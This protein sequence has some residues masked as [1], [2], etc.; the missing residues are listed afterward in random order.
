MKRPF[1]DQL[2]T[3]LFKLETNR[4][5]DSSEVDDKGRL[6]EPMEW[7]EQDSLANKLSEFMADKGY[8]FK[9]LIADIIARKYDQDE[10][11]KF[12][13]DFVRSKPVVMFSFTTCPFCRRAKDLLDEKRIDY[14]VIE[15]DELENNQ[16]N[17]IRAML[18]LMTKR[19][20]VPAI[21]IHGKAIGGMNDGMPGLKALNESGELDRWVNRDATSFGKNIF[22]I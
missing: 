18:G 16:G 3:L 17:E 5:K 4:V 7:S 11:R 20:S 12:I 13:Q 14:A 15:L 1:M 9:Q 6:G 8:V 21:F 22:N 10:T 2:A 19:T